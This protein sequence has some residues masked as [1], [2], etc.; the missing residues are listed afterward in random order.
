MIMYA[1]K[2]RDEEEEKCGVESLEREQDSWCKC[3]LL[4]TRLHPVAACH[5]LLSPLS[6]AFLCIL[7]ARFLFRLRALFLCLA[8]C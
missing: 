4:L 1:G 6:L 3:L 8:C 5:V 7:L 2:G